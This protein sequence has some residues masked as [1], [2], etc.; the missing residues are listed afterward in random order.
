MK[1]LFAK[2][3]QHVLLSLSVA[4][5]AGQALGQEAPNRV[6]LFIIDGLAVGAPDRIEDA[7]LQRPQERRRLLPSNALGAAGASGQR[8]GLPLELLFAQPDVNVWH[9]IYRGVRVSSRA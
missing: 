5:L 1:N 2:L 4:C 3:I 8:A 9:A 7:K 6:I